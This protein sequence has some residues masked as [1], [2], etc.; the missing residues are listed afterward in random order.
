MAMFDAGTASTKID[1]IEKS[2]EEYNENLRRIAELLDARNRI[3]NDRNDILINILE[4][5]K[6]RL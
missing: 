6:F 2:V 1:A 5:L 4:T 3:E